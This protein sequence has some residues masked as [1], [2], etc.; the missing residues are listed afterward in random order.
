L[1]INIHAAKVE[2]ECVVL[3]EKRQKKKKKD[4]ASCHMDIYGQNIDFLL[5][6]SISRIKKKNKKKTPNHLIIISGFINF[7]S[8]NE[9]QVGEEP[10]Q[11]SL[12]ATLKGGWGGPRATPAPFG[13]VCGHSYGLGVAP[14]S[15]WGGFS[16]LTWVVVLLILFFFFNKK[17]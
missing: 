16:S 2:R 5:Q 10:P 12:A 11:R 13:A 3:K 17:N 9:T 6:L 15:L 4:L 1:A 8:E 7:V 14:T